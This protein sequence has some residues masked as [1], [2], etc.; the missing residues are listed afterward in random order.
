MEIKCQQCGATVA[1]EALPP[2]CPLCG[3]EIEHQLTDAA[4]A[5]R[6]EEQGLATQ[7]LPD[8]GIA[9]GESDLSTLFQPGLMADSAKDDD[10]LGE[11][12]RSD[13]KRPEGGS[14]PPL[15]PGVEPYFLVSGAPPGE[16]RIV[17]KSARTSFGR[18]HAGVILADATVSA[19][20]FQIDVMG[21]EF[22]VRDLDSDSGTLLNGHRISHSEIFTGD[23]LRAGE[24]TLVF[25]TSGDGLP[26]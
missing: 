7:H 26:V 5:D 19:P 17:L 12:D 24:T 11:T 16:G 9:V 15:R 20:H 4:A 13:F 23:Q 22:F 6:N 18:A 10:D 8:R 14:P 25:R 1:G 3:I 2:R 21:G